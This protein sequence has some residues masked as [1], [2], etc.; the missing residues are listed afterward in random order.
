MLKEFD[1]LVA[2]CS[3][4]KTL[5]QVVS[6][7]IDNSLEENEIGIFT[8]GYGVVFKKKDK[9]EKTE[10]EEVGD[11]DSEDVKVEKE[12]EKKKDIP[13]GGLTINGKIQKLANEVGI[14]LKCDDGIIEFFIPKLDEFFEDG[15][16]VEMKLVKNG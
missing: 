3:K 10:P 5:E 13:D 12:V 11:Q 15:D 6:S 4:A 2:I 16:E 7:E 14:R 1:K 8:K 9:V